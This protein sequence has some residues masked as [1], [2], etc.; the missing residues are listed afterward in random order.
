MIHI[1]IVDD[2]N[3]LIHSLEDSL[4]F[5]EDIKVTFTANNGSEAIEQLKLCN[6]AVDVILMDIEM[7]EMNGIET[8]EFIKNKC[9]QIKI[10]MLTV[11]DDDENI[12]KSIQAGADGYLLK[13][14]NPESLYNAIQQ[15]LEGGAAMTPS[16]AKKTLQLLRNPISLE[17][18]YQA[19]KNPLSEREIEILEQIAKGLTYTGIAD[20]LFIAPATV[21][22]HIEN[23]YKKLRV[24][25]KIDARE[26]GKKRRLI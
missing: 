10:V 20:N 6:K 11:L 17:E 23:I 18:S 9:P 8:T 15:T 7:P 21:R 25:S 2:N 24:N 16:I 13:D 14:V 4:S 5:F 19:I 1:A 26:E 12:F 3:F 22:K